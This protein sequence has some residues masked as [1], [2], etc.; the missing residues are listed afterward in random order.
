MAKGHIYLT[1]HFRAIVKGNGGR[2]S[3]QKNPMLF[4]PLPFDKVFQLY[5]IRVVF[6]QKIK[7][8]KAPKI[9]QRTSYIN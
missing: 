4:V 9:L 7:L 3:L 1:E 8:L 2:G 6:L 5:R